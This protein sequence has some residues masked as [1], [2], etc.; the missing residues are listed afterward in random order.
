MALATGCKELM[1]PIF[2]EELGWT[3]VTSPGKRAQAVQDEILRIF[4]SPGLVIAT[5]NHPIARKQKRNHHENRN[6]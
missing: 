1:G 4:A 5:G 2:S 6:H 3:F